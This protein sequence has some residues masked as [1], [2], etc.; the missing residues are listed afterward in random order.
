MKKFERIKIG[1]QLEMPASRG[2]FYSDKD[3]GN[4]D[5]PI[6]AAIVT[7]R[8]HDPVERLDY[9]ALARIVVGGQEEHP[10]EKRTITGLARAGWRWATADWLAHAEALTA[11][12]VVQ[13][14]R[15]KKPGP[16]QARIYR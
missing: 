10:N 3:K 7:H 11:P 2:I 4:P 8:W 12:N 6:Q 15:K 14:G 9:V 5:R 16:A 13:L 1:D